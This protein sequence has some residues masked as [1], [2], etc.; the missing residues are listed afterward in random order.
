[1]LP[2]RV[3]GLSGRIFLIHFVHLKYNA[4]KLTVL[5]GGGN[6]IKG[7]VVLTHVMKACRGSGVIGP[8]ILNL[9]TRWR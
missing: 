4:L 2:L 1:M 8:V 7:D 3:F 6:G 9:G 5:L